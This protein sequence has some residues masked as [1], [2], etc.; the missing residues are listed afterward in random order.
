M[1]DLEFCVQGGLPNG[2]VA[3]EFTVMLVVRGVGVLYTYGVEPKILGE[4][5]GLMAWVA[6][7]Y[8]P[9]IFYSVAWRF[10]G[11]GREVGAA[12]VEEIVFAI[13]MLWVTQRTRIADLL[14]VVRLA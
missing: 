13:G 5:Y 3:V 1:R 4:F 11:A 9:E 12:F 7:W 14:R 6:A 10:M 8:S 2:G